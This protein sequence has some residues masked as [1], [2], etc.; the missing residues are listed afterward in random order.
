MIV[1]YTVD[2]VIFVCLDFREFVILG[3]FTSAR[4]RELSI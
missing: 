3:L 1:L 4:I 2:I